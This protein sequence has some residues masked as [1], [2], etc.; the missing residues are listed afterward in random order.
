M[1]HYTGPKAR[2]NRRLGVMIFE[3]NG[4]RKAA[5]RRDTPPGMHTKPSK[6]SGYGQAM[7]EKQK[8]KY[9][10]GLGERQLRRLFHEAS[11]RHGNTGEHL[12]TLCEMRLDNV[13]R[14]AGLTL[15]RPQARQGISHGHFRVN[16][17]KADIPSMLLRPGDIVHVKATVGIQ[18][19]YRTLLDSE[20]LGAAAFLSFDRDTMEIRVERVP[21]PDEF[22]LP[23][24]VNIVVELLT[25]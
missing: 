18:R 23:V 22:S 24:N 11:R 14:R 4:A 25:R 9:F 16:G 1:G 12:L 21:G 3:N 8:I 17:R 15:T 6:L 5:E 20:D 7:R 2:I 10:Y 13:I 19:L